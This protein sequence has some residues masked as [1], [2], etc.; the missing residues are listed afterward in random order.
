[1]NNKKLILALMAC[2]SLTALAADMA[3]KPMKLMGY[4]SDSKCA[5]MHNTTAPDAA[6]VKKCIA[7]GEKPVFVDAKKEVWSIDNPDSITDD[8][9]KAVTVMATADASA[10]SIHIDKVRSAKD[11]Q[12]TSGM[13]SH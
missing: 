1:M 5:A 9:G 12:G 2:S 3:S 10:K 4:I 8:Y 13:M 6:C 11:L 7:G